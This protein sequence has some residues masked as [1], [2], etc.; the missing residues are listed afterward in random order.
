MKI[1]SYHVEALTAGMLPDLSALLSQFFRETSMSE[2]HFHEIILQNPF[3]AKYSHQ[4]VDGG[5]VI[6]SELGKVVGFTAS[7]PMELY[8]KQTLLLGAFSG[9]TY[10]T[11]DARGYS[12]DLYARLYGKENIQIYYYNTANDISE[13]IHQLLQFK[14]GPVSC[15]QNVYRILDFSAF[16]VYCSAKLHFARI[17]CPPQLLRFVLWPLGFFFNRGGKRQKTNLRTRCEELKSI[18]FALFQRFHEELVVANTGLMSSRA[19]EALSWIY[20][21]RISQRKVFLLGRFLDDKLVG[22]IALRKLHGPFGKNR[23]T[24]LDWI[25]IRNDPEILD[26]L[27]GDATEFSRSHAGFMLDMA[28]YPEFVE[29]IVKRWL[30][31]LRKCNSCYSACRVSPSDLKAEI[32]Q[33]LHQSWFWGSFDGDRPLCEPNDYP[34]HQ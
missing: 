5:T 32:E 16:V 10:V 28:S 8:F 33:T 21:K 25:A 15:S 9:N 6:L 31:R 14:N 11:P 20:G 22:Y 1:N 24:V 17:H 2:E 7:Y 29:S 13:K 34:A 30:P 26:S 4:G 27:L 19:P 18:D 12:L 23:F 3:L